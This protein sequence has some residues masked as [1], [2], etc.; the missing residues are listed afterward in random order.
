MK[1]IR[2]ITA[3]TFVLLLALVGCKKEDSL[4]HLNVTA[5]QNFYSPND[6]KYVQLLATDGAS[7]V[8]EWEQAKA[9]DGGMVLYEVAFDKVG[10]DFSNPVY[11][12]T[13]DNNGVTNR[14]TISHK[15]LNKVASLAGIPSSTDGKIIWTV[16]SSKGINEVKSTQV[17]TLSLTTLAGIADPP[18]SIAITGDAT[19][20][21]TDASKAVN[22]KPV[23]NK[24]GEFE[25]YTKLTA[26]KNYSFI[27][28]LKGNTR[29]FNV[30]SGVLKEVNTPSTVAQTAVYRIHLDLNA[31]AATYTQIKKLELYFSPTDAYLFELPYIGNGVFQAVNQSIVFKQESWGRDERYKFRM[32]T[33]DGTNDSYEWW[34]SK[35]ADN[36]RPTAGSPASYWFM[37]PVSS[38]RWNNSFKFATEIDNS[39]SDVTVYFQPDKDY[40]HTVVKK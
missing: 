21:G 9:E 6:N 28:V 40:T 3:L 20:F 8:F 7:V 24:A 39:T 15:V 14:A 17:R 33:T 11:K 32:T 22:L 37:L 38:D 27:S 13:S 35:N 29:T 19:E 2:N 30:V 34:G 4:S 25:I 23:P 26:G 5:V 16:M 10:G 18:A 1:S 36:S 31:G 12:L